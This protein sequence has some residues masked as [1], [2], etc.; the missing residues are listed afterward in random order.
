MHLKKK[1]IL[2]EFLVR[3]VCRYRIGIVVWIITLLCLIVGEGGSNSIFSKF[4]PPKAFYNDHK[5]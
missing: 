1:R 5:L 4:S 2:S 3:I